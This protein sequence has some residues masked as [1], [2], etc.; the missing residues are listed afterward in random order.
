MTNIQNI[1]PLNQHINGIRLLMHQTCDV[2]T[3]S[4]RPR[5]VETFNIAAIIR[6]HFM[7]FRIENHPRTTAFISNWCPFNHSTH[8]YIQLQKL[9]N[10]DLLS[11]FGAIQVLH[12]AVGVK[13][14][15]E[16]GY[17]GVRFN[18]LTRGWVGGRASIFPKKKRYITLEWPLLGLISPKHI[19]HPSVGDGI[20]FTFRFITDE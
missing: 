7:L 17:E 11:C 14:P 18:V 19:S 6:R 8:N 15:G 16:K 10:V 20:V 2:H 4:L 12:N 1:F 9:S 3:N 5:T 13:F